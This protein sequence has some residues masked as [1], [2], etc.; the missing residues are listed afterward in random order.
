M[1][2]ARRRR[3][4]SESVF[5]SASPSGT[6]RSSSTT[7]ASSTKVASGQ[8]S[9]GSTGGSAAFLA[10]FLAFFFVAMLPASRLMG[11]DGAPPHL[12]DRYRPKPAIAARLGVQGIPTVIL[13]KDGKPV[14]QFV[15]VTQEG[16]LTAAVEEAL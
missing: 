5:E 4:A 16:A 12:A 15:G 6:L 3:A 14:Q 11:L 8:S 9:A 13:F 1:S 10:D 7:A 2:A